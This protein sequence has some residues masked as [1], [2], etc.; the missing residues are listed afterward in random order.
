MSSIIIHNFSVCIIIF[1]Y[2]VVQH[3]KNCPMFTVRN[4]VV[5]I[6]IQVYIPIKF[7]CTPDIYSGMTVT[8]QKNVCYSHIVADIGEN[9]NG[10]LLYF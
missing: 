6:Y 9:C 7:S 3:K 10:H 1:R 8:I 5:Q 2:V 4:V